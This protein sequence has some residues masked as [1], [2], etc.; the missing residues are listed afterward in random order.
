MQ[1]YYCFPLLVPNHEGNKIIRIEAINARHCQLCEDKIKLL[2]FGGFAERSSPSETDSN[3]VVFGLMDKCKA[4]IL[5]FCFLCTIFCYL[6]I[7]KL[8]RKQAL[9]GSNPS[10]IIQT[11]DEMSMQWIA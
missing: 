10:G 9:L 2:V 7:V 1:F 5:C 11:T 3:Y 4:R 8:K 6:C